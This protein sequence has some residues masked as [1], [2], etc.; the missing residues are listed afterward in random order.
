M[1]GSL[2]PQFHAIALLVVWCIQGEALIELF[3]SITAPGKWPKNRL[4]GEVSI[5]SNQISLW[6]RAKSPR[7]LLIP[8]T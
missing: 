8:N 1:F 5:R 7:H 3:K 2:I 4:V 6:D